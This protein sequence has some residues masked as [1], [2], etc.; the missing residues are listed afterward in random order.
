M[1]EQTEHKPRATCH[2]RIYDAAGT[3]ATFDSREDAHK[4]AYEILKLI[5]DL[6]TD[7]D[8]EVVEDIEPINACSYGFYRSD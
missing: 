8:Y 2:V 7:D 3:V 5:A 6:E 4:V 1:N